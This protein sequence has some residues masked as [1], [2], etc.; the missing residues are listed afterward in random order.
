LVACLHCGGSHSSENG[1]CPALDPRPSEPTLGSLEAGQILEGKYQI[2]AE[3]GRGAMGVVYQALH[4]ALGRRVAIKTLLAGT[5]QDPDLVARFEREAR[6]ASAIGHPHIVDVF[7]LGRTPDGQLFMAMEFL[8]GTSLATIL[9]MTPRLPIGLAVDF[10]SQML[11]GLAAAHRN[12]IVHRDLKPENIFILHTEDRPNFVKIVDFGI[13]KILALRPSDS[14][15]K[16]TGTAVGT[17]LGTPLYMSPEQILGQVDHI[18]HRSDIYS[19][20]VVLYEMLCGRTPFEGES[21]AEVFANILDNR[22]PLPRDL[23]RDIPPSLEAAIVRALDRDMEKRFATAA[24]MREAVSGRSADL[25]PPPELASAPYVHLQ[26]APPS[27]GSNRTDLGVS[28]GV[29]L[30][31]GPDEALKRQPSSVKRGDPFTP[32]TVN[33]PVPLLS[34]DLENPLAETASNPSPS[35]ELA[36]PA[37]IS[38]PGVPRRQFSQEPATPARPW[39]MWSILAM[40]LGLVAL[41]VG[42]RFVI[43]KVR[44]AASKREPNAQTLQHKLTLAVDPPDAVVQI[45]H[46]PVLREDLLLDQGKSHVLSATAPGRISRRFSFESN[47]D[48]ELSVFLGR[49]LVPPTPADPLPSPSESPARLPAKPAARD[50]I[51]HAFTKLDRYARCLALLD[52]TEGVARK[53]GS[54]TVPS[55]SNISVC[56]QLVEEANALTPVMPRL[57]NAGLSYL[58]GAQREQGPAILRQLFGTFRAEFFAARSG[59]QQEE[60]ARQEKDEGQTAAWH[61]RRM[62]L[63]ALAWLRM[64]K[65][66]SASTPAVKDYR[67]RLDQAHQALQEFAQNSPKHWAQVSGTDRFMQAAQEVVAMARSGS[68]RRSD[69][70]QAACTRLVDAFNEL[71]VE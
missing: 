60:L 32:P 51:N 18:D 22:Y 43:V 14:R 49:T 46:L 10:A 35:L 11:G 25:T 6:A 29:F 44:P 45:D 28:P 42:V 54:P 63:S 48:L 53:G 70:A 47:T 3:I 38:S 37:R 17:L 23:R 1:V 50:E 33:A 41:M 40:A 67:A 71:V 12:A 15:G 7:D 58:Q 66:G 8:D 2:V 69:A 61:M 13:S 4:V 20:G 5:G 30:Q 64:S 34:R 24:A 65:V 31:P 68:G 56:I 21:H 55:N 26:L 39:R 57:H 9:E 27:V 36:R 62:T 59:W 52:H 19:T 16:V